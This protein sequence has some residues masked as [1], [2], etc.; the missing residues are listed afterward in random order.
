MTLLE[1]RS[2]I[3]GYLQKTVLDLTVNGVDLSLLALNQVRR[4]AEMLHDFEFTRKHISVTVDGISG[5]TLDDAILE[6]EPTCEVKTVIEC[7]IYDDGFNLQPVEWTTVAESLERQ[8]QLKPGFGPRYPT[9]WEAATWTGYY[10]SATRIAI[11][12]NDIWIVPVMGE[13]KL[14]DLEFEVYAFTPDWSDKTD[15]VTVTGVLGMDY[16]DGTYWPYGTYNGRPFYVN[17]AN[18][19]IPPGTVASPQVRVIWYRPGEWIISAV[20]WIGQTPQSGNYQSMAATTMY[21]SG[22]YQGHGAWAGNGIVSVQ[23]GNS[24]T[25]IWLRHGAQYL[26]WAAI[27][28][29]NHLCKEFVFRQEGNL[30]PPEKLAE[31]ALE[32]FRQ[33]DAFKY[34]QDR[35]HVY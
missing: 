29:I 35:R 13:H 24:V 25:D 23:P 18:G 19:G 6:G 10:D 11:C 15:S 33:W 3:A 20:Q 7:G 9:D 26:M 32:T 14:F 28:Q 17:V 34:E 8:R 5:G 1:L 12:G 2:V 21:P 30:P 22:T 31:V 16:V 27:V 4:G